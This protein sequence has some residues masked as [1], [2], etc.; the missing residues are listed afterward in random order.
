M[1]GCGENND[2]RCFSY[3]NLEKLRSAKREDVDH[4]AFLRNHKLRTN[5]KGGRESGFCKIP[6]LTNPLHL[7]LEDLETVTSRDVTF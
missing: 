2:K 1:I 5:M 7:H 6:R 4:L 3:A